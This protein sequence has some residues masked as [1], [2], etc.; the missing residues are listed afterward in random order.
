MLM[1]TK[2]TKKN[3]TNEEGKCLAFAP[4]PSYAA[5]DDNVVYEFRCEKKSHNNSLAF[6]LNVVMYCV[7]YITVH[8]E[9][10]ATAGR[11]I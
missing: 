2:N 1:K 10:M 11:L 6:V 4:G 5:V 7:K 9:F 8:L 3:E